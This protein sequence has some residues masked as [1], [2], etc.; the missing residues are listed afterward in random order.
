MPVGLDKYSPSHLVWWMR[1]TRYDAARTSGSTL[2]VAHSIL[3]SHAFAP[4]CPS[5]SFSDV[6]SRGSSFI[7]LDAMN[8]NSIGSSTSNPDPSCPARDVWLNL[9]T[10][11][12]KYRWRQLQGSSLG[13]GG[14]GNTYTVFHRMV[15][16]PERQPSRLVYQL[17]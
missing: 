14:A 12:R 5:R 15:S 13:E 2:L 16:P 11:I 6:S 4:G 7:P 8:G 17:L 10:S 9:W 3:A 1:P